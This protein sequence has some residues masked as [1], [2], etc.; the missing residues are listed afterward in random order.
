MKATWYDKEPDTDICRR[1]HIDITL[2][3]VYPCGKQSDGRRH[4]Y[5]L[6]PLSLLL[7][8]AEE[9]DQKRNDDYSSANSDETACDA[10]TRP[11]R[12]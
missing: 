3:V 4:Q 2:L 1:L 5:K 6:G 12:I 11:N 8:E 10:T 9:K 7:C